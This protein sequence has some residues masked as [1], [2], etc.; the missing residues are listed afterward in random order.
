MPLRKLS[1]Q[2]SADAER[3]RGSSA[4]TPNFAQKLVDNNV[5]LP[6]RRNRPTNHQ[7]WNEV[8]IRPRP[9]VSPSRMSDG[10]YDRFVAAI[11]EADNET[12]TMSHL[13]PQIVGSPRYP[14]RQNVRFGNLDTLAKG[15]VVPQPD[16][17][18][19][20]RPGPGNRRLREQLRRAIVPS[21]REDYPFLPN[22]FVEAKGPAGRLR[23]GE[24]QA[25]QDGALGSRAMH[26]V[27]NLGRR[28]E[29]FD[30]KARTAS[31]VYHGRG[32]LEFS[33]HHHT[34][35]RGPGTPSQTHM[36]PLH[37]I[38]LSGSPTAFRQGVGAFRNASDY[39]HQLRKES[40]ENAHRRMEIITPEPPTTTPRLTRRSLS[41]Q[42][43][44]VES[45]VSN[46]S[47][48]SEQ[49]DSDDD[50]YEESS[51]AGPKRKPLKPK[52][53]TVTP[54][55]PARR[56]PSP[57]RLRPRRGSRRP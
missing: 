34:Q 31:V 28:E 24:L 46:T 12:E 1:G 47:D 43:P 42:T 16:Y 39:A 50:N 57:P 48:S 52:I 45:R 54:K 55:R 41:C 35:P 15:T 8:L 51:R 56:D 10:Q 6:N 23:V 20:E 7:D 36:T 33:T 13:F 30:N 9:S 27:E 44:L 37:S 49:E 21:S 38:A 2:S 22:F 5:S 53:V 4:Y 17:Y 19:G 11:D 25:C 3:T 26:R 29:V 32:T 18:E 40:I 14:S